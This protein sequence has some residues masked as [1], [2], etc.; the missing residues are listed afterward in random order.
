MHDGTR[1]LLAGHPVVYLSV[2][3]ADAVRRVGLGAGR[4]LLS[5]NPRATLKYLLDQRKPLYASVATY[6]VVTD[7]R[8]VEDIAAEV[9]ALLKV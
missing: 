3:L 7:G 5:V 4:P 9:T 8:E 1:A 2:E 6:T